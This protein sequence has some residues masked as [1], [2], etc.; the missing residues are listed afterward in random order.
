MSQRRVS[1]MGIGSSFD[2]FLKDEGIYEETRATAI[3]RV[4]TWQIEKAMK[5]QRLPKGERARR[6]DTRRG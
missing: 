1:K 6:M 4:L 3:N 5:K 2:S